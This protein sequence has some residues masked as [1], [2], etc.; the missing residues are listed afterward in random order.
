MAGAGIGVLIGVS[1]CGCRL[2][3]ADSRERVYLNAEGKGVGC[4]VGL[5]VQLIGEIVCKPLSCLAESLSC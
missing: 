2:S 4:G 3:S 5:M 1:R